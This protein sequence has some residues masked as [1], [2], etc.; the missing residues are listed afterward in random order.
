MVASLLQ[1]LVAFVVTLGILVSIHEFG[2]FWVARRCGIKV[3]RFSVGF[4]KSLWR[5]TDRQGTEYSVAAIPLGGYVKMLDEREGPVEAHEK[6]LAFNN[7]SVG[8]RIAVVAAGPFANF[9]LAIAALWLMYCI[10]M[11]VILPQVG[12]IVPESP[13][14]VAGIQPGDEIV[15]VNGVETPDWRAVNMAFLPFIGETGNLT[16]GI[17]PGRVGEQPSGVVTERIISVEHWLAG[18]DNPDFLTNL[19]ITPFSPVIPAVIGEVL[20]GGAAKKG[21]LISG[22]IIYRVNGHKIEGWQQWVD[23]IRENPEKTL[24]TIVFRKGVEQTVF[25]TPDSRD[26]EGRIIGYIGAGVKSFQWPEGML[27]DIRYGPID[28]LMKGIQGTWILTSTTVGSL[29]K[30]VTGLVS[31]NNLGG[32]ITIAKVASASIQSGL[33]SFLYFLAMLSVSLGVLNLL[34]I[35][36]LDGG[37]LL[38]Y[39]VELV[40]GKPLSERSQM[41]GLRVGVTLIVSVMLLALYNDVS[42]LF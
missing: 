37:H 9:L 30:M 6:H 13:A 27:R 31:V 23:V 15:S 32:P 25:L 28:G 5:K 39:L 18:I 11:Q 41:L 20:S 42:R 38:F 21:G 10:G 40:R 26:S 3:L 19:G 17:R 33:E 2:H 12:N 4:G 8:S 36:V 34:P 16:I 14:A 24:E 7:Q 29:W 35:P 1:T 22:D